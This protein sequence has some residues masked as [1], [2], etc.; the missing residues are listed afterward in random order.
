MKSSWF[1]CAKSNSILISISS[2]YSF[3]FHFFLLR[4]INLFS[5]HTANQVQVLSL[6]SQHTRLDFNHGLSLKFALH[7]IADCV[8]YSKSNSKCLI[9][10]V[11][12]THS[13]HVLQA[14]LHIFHYYPLTL[15]WCIHFQK[16]TFPQR[17]R[18]ISIQFTFK[19]YNTRQRHR[20]FV[21][22][23]KEKLLRMYVLVQCTWHHLLRVVHLKIFI[24]LKLTW[25][26]LSV[27][28][29]PNTVLSVDLRRFFLQTHDNEHC[30]SH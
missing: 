1:L 8:F 20:C 17:F 21:H 23:W 29:I 28:I 4:W 13:E 11:Q 27:L 15:I 16:S 6:C 22:K 5:F 30:R 25:A 18:F 12:L 7:A 3:C 19:L 26:F 10:P 14:F 2:S 9:A 24:P